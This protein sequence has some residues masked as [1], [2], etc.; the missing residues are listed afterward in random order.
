MST[1]VFLEQHEGELQ[2]GA[3]GVL[4]KAA[5]LGGEEVA[6]AIVGAGAAAL[7]AEAGRHG[8]SA[9]VD[10]DALVAA[11]DATVADITDEEPVR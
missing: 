5:S 3:L 11:Y 6:G 9:F 8:A 4:A 10:G 2:K 1:L 7:A